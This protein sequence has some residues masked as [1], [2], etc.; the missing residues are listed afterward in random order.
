MKWNDGLCGFVILLCAVVCTGCASQPPAYPEPEP[1]AADYYP[2]A[3]VNIHYSS[4]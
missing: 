3:P 1:S 2:A 4:H